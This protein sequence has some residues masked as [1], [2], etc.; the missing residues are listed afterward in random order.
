MTAPVTEKP[1][2]AADCITG[3]C[4]NGHGV[5]DNPTNGERYS[6]AFRDGVPHGQGTFRRDDGSTYVGEYKDG[7]MDG[8]GPVV[9][10]QS[11]FLDWA[12]CFSQ[13]WPGFS[14]PRIAL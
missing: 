2:S 1:M 6:G 4:V 13:P 7:L 14:F 12:L 3:D 8:H 5:Y 10:L 9:I 11:T